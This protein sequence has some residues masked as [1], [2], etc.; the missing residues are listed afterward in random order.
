MKYDQSFLFHGKLG[1]LYVVTYI[2]SRAV[3]NL[4]RV[5]KMGIS[6]RLSD[7]YSYNGFKFSEAIITLLFSKGFWLYAW[8]SL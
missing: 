3:Q 8:S 4:Y 1:G 7:V 6:T 2:L 5:M